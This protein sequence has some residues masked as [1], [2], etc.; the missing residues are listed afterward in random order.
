VGQRLWRTL[1]QARKE[2][3]GRQEGAVGPSAEQVSFHGDPHA[4]VRCERIRQREPEK[5][6]AVTIA[7]VGIGSIGPTETA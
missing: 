5:P 6:S 1:S 3:E 4:L 2:R 7:P